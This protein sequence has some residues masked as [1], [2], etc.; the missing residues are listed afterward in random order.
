[1]VQGLAG[2]GPFG[3]EQLLSFSTLVFLFLFITILLFMVK[4]II[5]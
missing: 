1:M 4:K 3:G 5:G 2:H